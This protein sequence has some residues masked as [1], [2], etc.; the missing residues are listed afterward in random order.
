VAKASR[1][2]VEVTDEPVRAEKGIHSCHQDF[3]CHGNLDAERATLQLITAAIS[4]GRAGSTTRPSL[5]LIQRR[6]PNMTK[7]QCGRSSALA[8]KYE[9]KEATEG[10]C[11]GD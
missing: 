10:P 6:R 1:F 2:R 7:G 11:V 8:C 3:P 9:R 5:P 4:G